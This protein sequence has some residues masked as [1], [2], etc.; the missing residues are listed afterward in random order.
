MHILLAEDD[1]HDIFFFQHALQEIAQPV[2][3]SV[4]QDGEQALNFLFRVAPYTHVMRPDIVLL[5]LNMPRKTGIDVLAA[6]GHDPELKCIPVIMFTTSTHPHDINRCYELGANAY[7]AKPAG[8]SNLVTA[9]KGILDFWGL[10]EFHK[11]ING[12]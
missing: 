8:V 2:E 4:V 1:P 11:R 3:L 5:D 7:I 12:E 9:L 10:C 6:L